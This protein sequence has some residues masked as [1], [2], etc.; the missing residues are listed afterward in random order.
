MT[1]ATR[2]FCHREEKSVIKF[3][4]PFSQFS[5]GDASDSICPKGWGIG[6]YSGDGSYSKLIRTIYGE[7]TSSNEFNQLSK[8]YNVNIRPDTIIPQIPM[9]LSREA[10]YAYNN[11]TIDS[12]KNNAYYWTQ[13][14]RNNVSAYL[15]YTRTTRFAPQF[16]YE[17]AYGNSL[18]C[19]AN[20]L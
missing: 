10:R 13:K 6:R 17:K 5:S 4:C 16:N 14:A 7:Y 2:S 8:E 18:R 15:L 1:K 12:S 9:S 11:G 19:V 20:M 3:L